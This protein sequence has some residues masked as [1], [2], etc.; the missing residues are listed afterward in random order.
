MLITFPG[1]KGLNVIQT[2]QERSPVNICYQ[3]H[4]LGQQYPVKREGS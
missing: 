2:W 1:F 3:L 4:Q